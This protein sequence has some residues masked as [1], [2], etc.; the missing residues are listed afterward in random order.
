NPKMPNVIQDLERFW[1]KDPNYINVNPNYKFRPSDDRFD[2]SITRDVEKAK[3]EVTKVKLTNVLQKAVRLSSD[4][5]VSYEE[6]HNL[7][8][9]FKNEPATKRILNLIKSEKIFL[10]SIYIRAAAY[11]E[12]YKG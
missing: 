12:C 4:Y 5:S 7:L 6:I 3:K 11:P 9:E 10:G 8:E 1:G 2:V